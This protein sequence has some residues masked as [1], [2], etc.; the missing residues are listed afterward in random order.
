MVERDERHAR[1]RR[2]GPV[3]RWR[4]V[5][6]VAVGAGAL[7]VGVAGPAGAASNEAAMNVDITG[8]SSEASCTASTSTCEWTITANVTVVN[9]SNQPITYEAVSNTVTWQSPTSSGVITGKYVSL[10]NPGV[11]ALEAGDTLAAGQRQTYS[12]YE[13]QVV[14]P[15]NATYGDLAVSVENNGVWGSGDAPF[16]EDG[17]ALPVT[18]LGGI[19]VG[20]LAGGWLGYVTVRRR[21]RRRAGLVG[22]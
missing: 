7:L 14:L 10:I 11:P 20:G 3:S 16:L 19:G 5:V 15:A 9:I 21:R 12:G 17:A 22:A 13:V 8:A 4:R 1:L 2:R 6:G 18:A